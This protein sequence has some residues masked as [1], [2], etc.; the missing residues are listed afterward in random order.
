MDERSMWAVSKV[1]GILADK[2]SPGLR[3]AVADELRAMEADDDIERR[4]LQSTAA[5][6]DRFADEVVDQ[7]PLNP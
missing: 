3:R 2:M 7:Q 4:F 5:V 6:L 1:V